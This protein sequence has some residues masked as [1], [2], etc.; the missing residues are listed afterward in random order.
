MGVGEDRKES[1]RAEL[2]VSDP[3]TAGSRVHL[4]KGGQRSERAE[5]EEG[6]CRVRTV[7]LVGGARSESLMRVFVLIVTESS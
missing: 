7:G 6:R 4:R 2:L 1:Q 3:G 5:R